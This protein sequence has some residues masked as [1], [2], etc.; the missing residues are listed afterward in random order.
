MH[1]KL[2]KKE[3]AGPLSDQSLAVCPVMPWARA[4]LWD[5]EITGTV[6]SV[7]LILGFSGSPESLFLQFPNIVETAVPHLATVIKRNILN[8]R[9]QLL[10]QYQIDARLDWWLDQNIK[11]GNTSSNVELALEYDDGS[12]TNHQ[13]KEKLFYKWS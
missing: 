8:L 7:P 3:E 12:I 5:V 11:S 4:P 2:V 9:L 1:S 6:C 13:E 10:K